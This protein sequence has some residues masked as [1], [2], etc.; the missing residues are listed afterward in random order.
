M[1]RF[2]IDGLE[3]KVSWGYA[4]RGGTVHCAI[5]NDDGPPVLYGWAICS[6]RDRF[7]RKIG[8]KVALTRAIKDMPRDFRSQVWAAYL[9]MQHGRW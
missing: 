9:N 2:T 6:E 5:R 8:R 4:T 3:Y 1:M 7:T